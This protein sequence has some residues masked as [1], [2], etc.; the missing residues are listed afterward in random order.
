MVIGTRS[1]DSAYYLSEA[2]KKSFDKDGVDES[3]ES[4]TGSP[5][6]EVMKESENF[7]KEK[8]LP[9]SQ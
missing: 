3:E 2:Y 1:F 8:F 5:E 9:H 7:M 4:S 6:D